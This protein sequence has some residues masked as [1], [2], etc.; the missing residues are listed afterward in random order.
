VGKSLNRRN[1]KGAGKKA[2]A[3]ADGK[4]DGKAGTTEGHNAKA[5]AGIIRSVCK[6]LA[7]LDRQ[8]ETI[9]AERRELLNS[10]VKVDLD[11]TVSDFRIAYRLYKLEGEKRDKL[12]DTMQE[13]FK[14]LGLGGQLNFLEEIEKAE[15]DPAAE[16][17]GGEQVQE[18]A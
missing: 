12:L 15:K 6:E 13:T 17:P 10:K 8:S 2:A 5:R 16:P 18:Q 7:D 14:A 1:A 3:P 4:P 9:N 11:M